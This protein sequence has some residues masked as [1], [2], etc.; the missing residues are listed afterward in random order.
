MAKTRHE[1]RDGIHGFIEFNNLEKRLIDSVPFQRLR[2]IHQLAM[3]YQV[4]PAR[5]HK[6]FEHSL[7]VMEVASRIFDRIFS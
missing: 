4:Y 3:T 5:T 2:N 1:V 6:R 7:G